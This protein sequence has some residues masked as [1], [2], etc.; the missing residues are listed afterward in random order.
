ML[1]LRNS[2][3]SPSEELQ[4]ALQECGNAVVI[5]VVPESGSGDRAGPVPGEPAEE[6]EAT[7]VPVSDLTVEQLICLSS[8]LEPAD[9]ARVVVATSSGDLST[10]S[11]AVLPALTKCDV[12]S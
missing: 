5:P 9:L 1:Q 4:E 6:P 2:E 7:P 11:D 3:G 12:G 8:E 10:L